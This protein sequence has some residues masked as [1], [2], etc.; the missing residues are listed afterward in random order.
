MS[1]SVGRKLTMAALVLG[2]SVLLSRV[3]GF[4]RDAVI[5][6]LLGA[7][8]E[9]DTYF[10]A[11]TLPDL[12]NYFLAGGTLS[13]TFLPLYSRYLARGDAEGGDRFTSI[14]ITNIGVILL[15]FVVL[16]EFFAPELVR[17]LFP[18]FSELQLGRT[19]ELTRI[20]MPG[21]LFFVIGGVL[22]AILMAHERFLAV[23]LAPLIYNA[24]IIIFGAILHSTMGVAGFSIGALVGAACGP[25][26]LPLIHLRQT[27]RFRLTF[28]PLDR[29]FLRYL[30]IALPLMA[31]VTL[32]TA[33]EWIGRYWGS[34]LSVG[35]ITWL[36]NARRL[37]LVPMALIG[38]AAGQAALPFLSRLLAEG[39]D[40]EMGKVLTGTLRAALFLSLLCATF[41]AVMAYPIV[42]AVFQRGLYSAEDAARTGAILV[43]FCPAI[44]VWTVQ[45]VAVRGFYARSNTWL[46]MLIGTVVT[47]LA[48]PVY[49]HLMKHLDAPGL[50]LATSF[51]VAANA[52]LTLVMLNVVYGGIGFRSLASGLLKGL[53]TAAAAAIPLLAIRYAFSAW[54]DSTGGLYA[55][56]EIGIAGLAFAFVVVFV[57]R[58][59]GGPEGEAIARVLSKISRGRL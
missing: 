26:L 5:A 9:T 34:S 55:W 14:I 42:A 16:G 48:L 8:G 54:H 29:E 4:V 56:A 23:A 59:L 50:A 53:V 58:R 2:T 45:V 11:F 30:V 27:F 3:L 49:Y 57:S 46:P 47:A 28:A 18:G 20:V 39:K 40:K 21:Q 17:P 10:A 15:T 41:A 1:K 25:F 19:A 6:Y 36:N 24:S 37:M 33:D 13:I 7:G 22:G 52:A 12:M 44:V 32:L 38:Q 31:G 51:G 35:T 43:A